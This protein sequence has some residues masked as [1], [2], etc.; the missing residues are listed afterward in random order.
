M[1]DTTVGLTWKLR[2]QGAGDVKGQIGQVTGAVKGARAEASRAPAMGGWK[3]GFATANAGASKLWGTLTK[4][5][6]MIGL[7]AGVMGIASSAKSF[8]ALDQEMIALQTQLALTDAETTKLADNFRK[9][10]TEIG[11]PAEEIAGLADTMNDLGVTWSR[12]VESA[13]KVSLFATGIGVKDI[14]AVGEAFAGLEAIGGG[15]MGIDKQLALLREMQ[16]LSGLK[17]EDFFGAASKAARPMSVVGKLQGETGIKQLGAIIATLGK[18]YAAQPRKIQS[19]LDQLLDV[20]EKAAS[21]PEFRRSMQHL[22]INFKDAGTMFESTLN[23]LAKTPRA[24]DAVEGLPDEFKSILGGAVKNVA[25]FRDSMGG[26]VG[27]TDALAA[28]LERARNSSTAE[29][30]KATEALKQALIPIV[31]VLFKA[32]AGL[33][34]F[35]TEKFPE[36]A[37]MGMK[38]NPLSPMLGPGSEEYGKNLDEAQRKSQFVDALEKAGWTEIAANARALM[39]QSIDQGEG[40]IP[41]DVLRRSAGNIGGSEQARLF[42]EQMTEQAGAFVPEMPESRGPATTADQL[43]SGR[44]GAGSSSVD[45]NAAMAAFRAMMAPSPGYPDSETARGRQEI[46]IRLEATVTS[47]GISATATANQDARSGEAP[48]IVRVRPGRTV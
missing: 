30:G 33:A 6:G 15:T 41:Y 37:A 25:A 32:L 31:E 8:L 45:V 47:D 24:L 12:A 21:D 13:S 23:V 38:D 5:S 7:G 10:A 4:M 14:Q 46:N 39:A 48:P 28:D 3:N 22:G 18:T 36:I 20:F 2:A 29:L 26:M 9:M 27:N 11:K 1:S 34:N 35:I 17:E 42:R 19:G 43:P 40:L 44:P 16:R